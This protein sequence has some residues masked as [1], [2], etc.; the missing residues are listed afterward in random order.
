MVGTNEN[1]HM[2]ALDGNDI[3]RGL[4]RNDMMIGGNGHDRMGGADGADQI[5]GDAGN[6][7]ILGGTGADYINGTG[8][9]DVI[10]ARD[11]IVFSDGSIDKIVC[12]LGKDRAYMTPAEGDQASKDC[13]KIVTP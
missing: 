9:D 1:D 4:G 10:Y 8:G 2:N 6:D 5:Y 12:G 11:S 3:L 7:N 13:E